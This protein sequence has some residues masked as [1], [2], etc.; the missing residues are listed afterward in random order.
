M[1]KIPKTITK[2]LHFNDGVYS[3]VDCPIICQEYINKVLGSTPS[4]ILIKVSNFYQKKS[5]KQLI[6]R[7]TTAE[8]SWM[9]GN[10]NRLRIFYPDSRQI[11]LREF[12][13]PMGH[14]YLW[15]KIKAI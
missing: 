10:Q 12:D 13:P 9:D 5:Y 7:W 1:K 14:S 6:S 4:N 15:I 3:E 2:K 8:L 11:I